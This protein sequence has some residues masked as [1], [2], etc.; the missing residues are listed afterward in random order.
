V[1]RTI[2]LVCVLLSGCGTTSRFQGDP[3]QDTDSL[4]T[5]HEARGEDS[6]SPALASKL[7]HIY[8]DRPEYAELITRSGAQDVRLPRPRSMVPPKYPL[9]LLL[10]KV[11]ARVTVAFVVNELGTVLDPRIV[12]AP[13]DRFSPLALEAVGKWSFYPGSI[14]GRSV[15]FVVVAPIVFKPGS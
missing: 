12:E 8:E 10:G 1:K 15:S 6:F 9:G 14:K 4:F 5:A 7:L 13:D 2:L 11:E 3:I